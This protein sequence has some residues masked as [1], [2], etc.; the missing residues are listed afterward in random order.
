[1]MI[2]SKTLETTVR[3]FWEALGRQDYD[4]VKSFF[5]DNAVI[6]WPNTNEKFTVENYIHVNKTYPGTW[7]FAFESLKIFDSQA[8]SVVRILS[9]DRK[10]SLRAISLFGFTDGRISELT[11]YFA[12]DEEVPLWRQSSNK[13][14]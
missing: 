3:E 4:T 13:N 14:Q 1:M 11:E 12:M 5:T 6:Y 8:L 9:R 7:D 2:T 10:E